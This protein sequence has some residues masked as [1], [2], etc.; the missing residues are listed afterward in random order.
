MTA[1]YAFS[2]SNETRR[3]GS[4]VAF[5][6]GATTGASFA[7]ESE[8]AEALTLGVGV[9]LVDVSDAAQPESVMAASAVS[10]TNEALANEI[11]DLFE[12]V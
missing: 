9:C 10:A 5:V 3:F 4:L 11:A 1:V 6:V 8:P 12:A 2:S 7:L